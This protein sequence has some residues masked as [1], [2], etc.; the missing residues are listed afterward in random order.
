MDRFARI[1]GV[2]IATCIVGGAAVTV[3][4]ALL[5]EDVWILP[6][7]VLIIGGSLAILVGM[8]GIVAELVVSSRATSGD[9]ARGIVGTVEMSPLLAVVGTHEMAGVTFRPILHVDN[10]GQGPVAYVIQ[11]F[12]VAIQPYAKA[13][14]M[15]VGGWP[16]PPDEHA[17]EHDFQLE[18]A[19]VP[20]P[21]S[22]YTI[23]PGAYMDLGGPP[24]EFGPYVAAGNPIDVAYEVEVRLARPFAGST[25]VEHRRYSFRAYV[26]NEKKKGGRVGA[27]IRQYAADQDPPRYV[28]AGIADE[29]ADWSLPMPDASKGK[30]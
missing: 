22:V 29:S 9:D 23:A 8:V 3:G 10:K 25:V 15:P 18:T 17:H 19:S 28:K 6:R 5:P 7:L 16:D 30:K 12:D 11:R 2:W 26:H 14:S 4:G 13:F 1:G 21:S 24:R 27:E 20:Y